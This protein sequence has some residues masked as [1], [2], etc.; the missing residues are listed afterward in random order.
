VRVA[1]AS[2]LQFA[3]SRP[4]ELIQRREFGAEHA[5]SFRGQPVGLTPIVG[6]Q[7][8]DQTVPLETGDGAV[9]EIPNLSELS[10]EGPGS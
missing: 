5:A 9:N 3:Q 1:V 4:G 8:L 7:R 10:G 6:R 2:R